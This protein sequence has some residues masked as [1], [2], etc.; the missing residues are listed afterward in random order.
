MTAAKKNLLQ[1]L[2]TIR[3]KVTKIEKTAK[4]NLGGN[5][6]YEAMEHDHVVAELRADL[7]EHN[8]FVIPTLVESFNEKTGAV[9]GNGAAWYLYRAI[10]DVSFINGDD[11]ADL[12]TVR[13][14][15]ASLGTDDKNPGKAITY[16][17]KSALLKMFT[18]GTLEHEEQVPDESQMQAPPVN[19]EVW[20]DLEKAGAESLE[21]LQALYQS[22]S[23][24]LQDQVYGDR[25]QALINKA[26]GVE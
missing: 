11:Y 6:S 9:T 2:N 18:L 14:E 7:V 1:K 10:Y 3:K 22:L 16:A 21:K 15:G 13:T 26:S 23:P 20:A 19:P 4:V 8:I 24:T 17:T 12:W 25:L 5:R